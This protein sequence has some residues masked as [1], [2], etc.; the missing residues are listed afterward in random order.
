MSLWPEG[1]EDSKVPPP[2]PR[3]SGTS[4]ARGSARRLL[5]L[6]V[7]IC[8]ARPGPRYPY[9]A[10]ETFPT[11]AAHRRFVESYNTRRVGRPR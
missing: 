8:S 9:L 7:R 6:R 2:K 1:R 11:D 10:E 4:V 3:S 5:F